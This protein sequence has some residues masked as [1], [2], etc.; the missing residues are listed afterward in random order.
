MNV[1]VTAPTVLEHARRSHVYNE[2]PH[3]VGVHRQVYASN[4]PDLI[5]AAKRSPPRW[6]AT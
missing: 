3:T 5:L 4:W 2:T 6:Y 1:V